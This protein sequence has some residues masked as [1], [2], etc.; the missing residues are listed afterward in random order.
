MPTSHSAEGVSRF[1]GDGPE[2]AVSRPCNSRSIDTTAFPPQRMPALID[3]TMRIYS[4]IAVLKA[5]MIARARSAN[6][7]FGSK[8]EE[9]NV[10]NSG[11]LRRS[12]R[13]SMRDHATRRQQKTHDQ[14]SSSP[15]RGFVWFKM[16]PDPDRS[17][18]RCQTCAVFDLNGQTA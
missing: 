16:G 1:I 11:P 3:S 6:C 17:Y 8:C 2:P 7:S 12:K 18:S 13:T 15:E 9:L 4:L 14:N 5:R 10:S